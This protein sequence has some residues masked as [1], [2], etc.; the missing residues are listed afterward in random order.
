M[1]RTQVRSLVNENENIKA[2]FTHTYNELL[3]AFEHFKMQIEDDH[4]HQSNVHEQELL[5]QIDLQ[6]ERVE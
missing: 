4:R 6:K 3:E 2:T 5:R 1:L